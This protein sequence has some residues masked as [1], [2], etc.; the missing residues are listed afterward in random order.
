[1]SKVSG[2]CKRSMMFKTLLFSNFLYMS[3][4]ICHFCENLNE[5]LKNCVVKIIHF[6]NINTALILGRLQ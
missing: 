4:Q 1:M 6:I 3:I 2:I 5:K